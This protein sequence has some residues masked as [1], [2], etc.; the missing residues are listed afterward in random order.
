MTAGGDGGCVPTCGNGA[1]DPAC[2]NCDNCA[3]D[4][5]C[6]PCEVCNAGVCELN[7]DDGLGCNGVETCDPVNGC[8]PGTPP[9]CNDS[10]GCTMNSCENCDPATDTS[11]LP[12]RYKCVFTPDDTRCDDGVACN[13]EETCLFGTVASSGCQAG[14]PPNCSDGAE[15][16]ADTCE[17]C[18]PATD[19]HCQLAGYKCVHRPDD[20]DAGNI[21]LTT[22]VND[23][24]SMFIPVGGAD[25]TW[26]VTCEATPNGALP[27]PATVITPHPEWDTIMGSQWISA[28]Y[29]G[30]NGNYCYQ[31]CFCLAAGFQNPSLTFSIL[32][33]DAADVYLNNTNGHTLLVTRPSVPAAYD[34]PAT[35]FTSNG[36][37]PFAAGVNCIEV[38]VHEL[39]GMFTGFDLVGRFTATNAKCN[40]C[41]DGAFCDGEET[42]ACA[43][44][45]CCSL[46]NSCSPASPTN[47]SA[48]TSTGGSWACTGFACAPGTPPTCDETPDLGCTVDTCNPALAACMAN[49][50]AAS[51]CVHTPVNCSDNIGCTGDTCMECPAGDATCLAVGHRCVHTP[52]HGFCQNGLGCDGQEVCNPAAPPGTG[53]QDGMDPICND[54]IACTID[55]CRE[56]AT[57]GSGCENLGYECVFTPNVALCGNGTCESACE[58]C[59]TCPDDCGCQPAEPPCE[60]G[61]MCNI[62]TGQCDD[63]PDAPPG[64][65]CEADGDILTGDACNGG[66]LCIQGSP[67]PCPDPFVCPSGEEPFSR[68]SIDQKGSLLIFSKIE[69]KWGEDGALIQDTFLDITNDY[70]N[71]VTIQGFFINGDV[72]LEQLCDDFPCTPGNEI[73]H[74]E[75]GWN[76]ADCR[77]TLTANQP[78]YWSAA[79]GSDKCQ[80]FVVLDEDGPGRPDPETGGDT[81]VLRGY[82]VFYAVRFNPALGE[83]GGWEEIRWNHLKGDAVLVNYANGTA[84]EYN[85]WAAQAHCS[86]HGAPL[87][88]CTLRDLNGTCCTAEVIPGRL[89]LDGFQYDIAFDDLL[90]DFYGSGSDVLSGGGVTATVDTDLTVH[91]VSADLRQD[92]CGPVLTKVEA[93][94]CNEFESCFSGTRR[95]VCCW[96]QTMLSNWVR[97]EAI[98]N[99]FMRSALRTDK[100]K[101]RL[102][103]VHS[104]ECDFEELCGPTAFQKMWNCRRDSMIFGDFSEDAA[105]LGL[106]TKFIAFSGPSSERATAG[107]NLVGTGEERATILVDT[108]DGTPELSGEGHQMVR[109]EGG[110]DKASP[111]T[112]QRPQR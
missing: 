91:A 80:P 56:C 9:I 104:N 78:H 96:D 66:G 19:P 59:N 89:D 40:T 109:P 103:G 38:V 3:A 41:D 62:I 92:G 97:S 4:C 18:D 64:T 70:P 21:N 61:E 2:E 48:C 95:C 13:G 25:D 60:G 39:G 51:C 99:H 86:T 52:N 65:P 90:L 53:C 108:D 84:W 57:A 49:Q 112:D 17:E 72:E 28:N 93:E 68:I 8:Q 81:R 71:S 37:T 111:R 20:S 54:S 82:A 75:P 85:A 87:L 69:I 34:L 88:D 107:M 1:C 30:P 106:A 47:P 31:S 63:L 94:I 32:A 5:G 79:T 23:G 77:F 98:P 15:C 102:D 105:I 45:E 27:R 42:C 26:T 33:D 73:Q 101:A 110:S 29:E 7:C 6:N 83:D 58:N 44:A 55:T 36:A 12:A 11:C 22:G 46:N 76:T 74:F 16:S 14:T 24:T 10:I 100:G 35:T 43:T 67:I 50:D